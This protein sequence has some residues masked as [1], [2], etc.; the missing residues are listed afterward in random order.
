MPDGRQKC[1]N[2]SLTGVIKTVRQGAGHLIKMYNRRIR[3][4][5]VRKGWERPPLKG[6]AR[7]E[8]P[9]RSRGGTDR[10]RGRSSDRDRIEAREVQS[11]RNKNGFVEKQS[12]FNI[13]TFLFSTLL[14]K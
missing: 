1:V 8:Q 7:S 14:S 3:V 9:M 5:P 10:A 2:D 11:F 4:D 6:K 12:K 13:H